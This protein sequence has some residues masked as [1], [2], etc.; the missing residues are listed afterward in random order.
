MEL[1]ASKALASNVPIPG[2]IQGNP[3][4]RREVETRWSL[5]SFSSQAILWFYD[6][7]VGRG[8]VM[9]F[10]S[11][12]GRGAVAH[13]PCPRWPF[14]P[15]VLHKHQRK[16]VLS[17]HSV[18]LCQLSSLNSLLWVQW[19]MVLL[20][21]GRV[22]SLVLVNLYSS[23]ANFL[24]IFTS[25]KPHFSPFL[26]SSKT[27]WGKSLWGAFW[28]VRGEADWVLQEVFCL[29]QFIN[30]F[31]ETSERSNVPSLKHFSG[32]VLLAKC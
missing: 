13:S 30:S 22:A 23:K 26:N 7:L 2:G 19:E 25:L 16:A 5:W 6:W 12:L 21:D 10:C 24:Q 28:V 1:L 18:T 4:H 14:L 32:S 31:K 27:D 15:H 9:W 29:Q 20:V 17:Q 11:A 8:L 3:T